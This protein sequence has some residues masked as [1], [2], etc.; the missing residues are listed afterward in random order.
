MNITMLSVGS[1]GDVRPYVLLGKELSSRGHQITIAAFS[2]FSSM[3]EQ[4]GLRFFRLSGDAE[5]MMHAILAPDTN[6]LSFLPRLKKSM[7]SVAQD[8][9]QDMSDSCADADAMVCNFF[10]TIYYSIAEKYRI[11]C[12]QTQY[13]PMDPTRDMPIS[14]IRNQHLGA[15]VNEMTYKLGYLL[16]GAL[17]KSVL[18]DWREANH[19]PARLIHAHPDYLVNG[20]LVPVIYAVSPH[21][22]PRPA[23]W[24]E[25]IRMSGFWFDEEPGN[26]EPAET[27]VRFIEDGSRPVYIGFG[28][29]NSG[30][31]NRLM[32]VVLRALHA[33]KLRA[34]IHT[35][36]S[37]AHLRSNRS[38]F[39]T[40]FVPHDWLF[41]RMQA[42]VHHGGAGTTASGLRHGKPTLII[43]FGGDQAFWGS[44]VFRLG[45]GPRPIARER[46]TVSRLSSALLDLTS[47]VSYR[48]AADAL[49]KKL[50]EEHGIRI[51]C[52]M[53]EQEIARWNTGSP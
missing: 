52:D 8:L 31:M 17:E 49:G 1:T 5:K 35:G 32:T 6:G 45:C 23:D 41:P 22:L 28:S 2:C 11:P 48:T 25:N 7:G 18:S 27:L 33:T 21:V 44:R 38:V 47:R 20:H 13:F 30:N 15:M 37:G 39:F 50:A 53:I 16:I 12:I 36:W 14:V 29:M 9:I 34:V 46:I 40:D 10:G 24:A 19:V 3:V 51:A 4:A 42:V 26:P 43:P